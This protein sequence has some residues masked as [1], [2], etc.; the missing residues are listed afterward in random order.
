MVQSLCKRHR[1]DLIVKRCKIR[2]HEVGWL[3]MEVSAQIL[4]FKLLI[5]DR[6]IDARMGGNI[7]NASLALAEIGCPACFDPSYYR[8]TYRVCKKGLDHAA[9]VAQGK[10]ADEGFAKL[11]DDGNTPTTT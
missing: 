7:A 10:R 5:A 1:Y 8:L 6:R 11:V 3:A 9:K 2:E 4:L